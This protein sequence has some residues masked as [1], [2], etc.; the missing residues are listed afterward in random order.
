MLERIQEL[1]AELSILHSTSVTAPTTSPAG[2][3]DGERKVPSQADLIQEQLR[4]KGTI[5]VNSAIGLVEPME[6][7][8]E[9]LME[10]VAYAEEEEARTAELLE[11]RAKSGALGKSAEEGGKVPEE[12]VRHPIL[13]KLSDLEGQIKHLNSQAA[14]ANVEARRAHRVLRDL[15]KIGFHVGDQTDMVPSR[16]KAEEMITSM[17]EVVNSIVMATGLAREIEAE[18][19]RIA[20]EEA[21]AAAA[22][23]AEEDGGNLEADG[24]GGKEDDEEEAAG[25]QE[26][27]PEEAMHPLI[28]TMKTLQKEI[29]FIQ[30]YVADTE[31]LLEAVTGGTAANS[32]EPQGLF[33]LQVQQ[34]QTAL[35]AKEEELARLEEQLKNRG[36]EAQMI[37]KLQKDLTDTEIRRGCLQGELEVTKMEMTRLKT[38]G[39][40]LKQRER[41]STTTTVLAKGS[42]KEGEAADV[43]GLKRLLAAKQAEADMYKSAV[44]DRPLNN[45]A[46]VMKQQNDIIHELNNEIV[47]LQNE[48]SARGT[49][50]GGGKAGHAA[51]VASGRANKQVKDLQEALLN[52]QQDVKHLMLEMRYHHNKTSQLASDNQMLAKDNQTMQAKLLEMANKMEAMQ[53]TLRHREI[54]LADPRH[55]IKQ[56]RD[57]VLL[58]GD[59]VSG[60][61]SAG[62]GRQGYG[63]PPSLGLGHPTLTRALGDFPKGA[64]FPQSSLMVEELKTTGILPKRPH[65]MSTTERARP[66]YNGYPE[67]GDLKDPH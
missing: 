37:V 28:K 35:L 23:A 12:A 39:F 57:Q 3:D 61:L 32:G 54:E 60:L 38:K 10:V 20:E 44:A 30:D 41:K 33:G 1:E 21:A 62:F 29:D 58:P 56:T 8:C 19:K 48:A 34:L 50:A 14:E 24:E 55:M 64:A 52:A 49:A 2:G 45:A 63:M 7:I 26:G 25:H 43:E 42:V 40:V 46:A 51:L 6:R 59:K 16:E 22:A 15:V 11:V 5:N 47:K 66:V 31:D 67:T 4:R 18:Q 65:P 27:G 53:Q 36:E 9:T 13:L 17:E